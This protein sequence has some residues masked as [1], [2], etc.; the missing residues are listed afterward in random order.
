MCMSLYVFVLHNN[1][2]HRHCHILLALQ[3]TCSCKISHCGNPKRFSCGDPTRPVVS[4]R[5]E[6]SKEELRMC[7]CCSVEMECIRCVTRTHVLSSLLPE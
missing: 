1:S 5:R 2:Q 7:I 4:M 6:P 3:R